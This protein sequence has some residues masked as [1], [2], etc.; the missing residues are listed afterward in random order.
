MFGIGT[1]SYFNTEENERDVLHIDGD[2]DDALAEAFRMIRFNMP[3]INKDARV[4]ML[5]STMPGEGKTF[6]SGNFAATLG[7]T[8]KKVVLVDADIR[9]RTRSRLASKAG[10]YG[11]TSFLSG[12]IDDVF[13]LVAT[14]SKKCNLDILPAGI[15]A[16]NPTELLMSDRL[17][18]CVE[19]LKTRYDY[20]IIDTG[21]SSHLLMDLDK[22]DGPRRWFDWSFK[23]AAYKH[24]DLQMGWYLKDLEEIEPFDNTVIIIKKTDLPYVTMADGYDGPSLSFTDKSNRNDATALVRITVNPNLAV[25][26][27]KDTEAVKIKVIRKAR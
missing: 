15:M 14:A 11:L 7:L 2:K 6:I 5:T 4:I 3:F 17:E 23:K 25:R 27:N 18:Q 24:Y 12:N 10:D 8:G 9:K 22:H 16:P 19:Q 26:Y 13:S 21:G 20:V 1:G